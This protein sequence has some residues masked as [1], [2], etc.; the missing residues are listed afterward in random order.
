[1]A[2]AAVMILLAIA[3]YAYLLPWEWA[4]GYSLFVLPGW[5][6]VKNILRV[7]GH[8]RTIEQIEA[9]REELAKEVPVVTSKRAEKL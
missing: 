7:M 1:M 5:I 6:L 2:V 4:R 3:D 8:G 9:A